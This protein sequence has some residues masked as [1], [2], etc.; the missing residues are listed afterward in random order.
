MEIVW[1]VFSN[2]FLVMRSF[3]KMVEIVVKFVGNFYNNYLNN[4]GKLKI[5]MLLIVFIGIIVVIVGLGGGFII[6]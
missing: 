5:V 2:E 3:I 4:N 6:I 1:V